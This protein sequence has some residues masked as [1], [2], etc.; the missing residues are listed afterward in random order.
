MRQFSLRYLLLEVALI[1]VA[2]SIGLL[3]FHERNWDTER[4]A[5]LATSFY[6]LTGPACGGLIHSIWVGALAGLVIGPV[7]V[8]VF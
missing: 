6:V 4:G 1:A 2:V 5:I 3:L 8:Y 7:L